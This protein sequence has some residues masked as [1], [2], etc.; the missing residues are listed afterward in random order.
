MKNSSNLCLSCFN[1]Y[2]SWC[3]YIYIRVMYMKHVNVITVNISESQQITSKLGGL[4]GYS[5]WIL[6]SADL[7]VSGN[8]VD[9][10]TFWTNEK[11]MMEAPPTSLKGRCLD[12]FWIYSFFYYSNIPNW[13]DMESNR[14]LYQTETLWIRMESN[15][16]ISANTTTANIVLKVHH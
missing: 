6:W 4:I 10:I 2:T 15:R 11:T 13:V 1:K 12:T 3:I 7:S 16:K 9:K 8:L 5:L 14:S